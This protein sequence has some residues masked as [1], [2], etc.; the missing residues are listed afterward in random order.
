V[1]PGGIKRLLKRFIVGA[2]LSVLGLTVFTFAVDSAVFRYRLATNRQPYAT[3]RVRHYYAVLHKN[4]KTEFLF[5]PPQ[6][7][8]CIQALFPHAGFA[9]CWYLRR[10][11]EQRTNI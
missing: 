6:D 3:V 1:L 8:T 5:D 10:H 7:T 9:A 4:G 2:F 11:S